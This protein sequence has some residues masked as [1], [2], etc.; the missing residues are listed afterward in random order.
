[1]RVFCLLLLGAA[2]LRAQDVTQAAAARAAGVERELRGAVRITGR[3]DSVFTLDERMRYYHVPGVSVAIIEDNRLVY[4]KG[5][6]V[7]EFGDTTQVDTTTLFLAGSISKPVFATGVLKLVQ[8]GKL[9]L[10]EDVNARLKSWRLPASHFTEKEKVT[11]R[12]ILTHTAGLTVWGFPGYA[13]TATVPTV[14]QVLD[15]EKPANTD[16]VRNDTTPGARWLYSGGGFTIAQLL[17]SDVTGESFPALMRRLVLAPAGMNRST[18]ENPLP[19]ARHGEAATGHEVIDTPIPGRFHTYPEMSAAGLW[20][21]AADLARWAID[22]SRAFNG[23]TGRILS[24]EMARQMISSQVTT[25]P[26]GGNRVWGLSVA[27]NGTG[28]SIS[29]SHGGRDEGFVASAMMWPKLGRGYVIL[30]NGVNGAVLAEF[31]RAFAHVYGVAAPARPER[32]IVMLDSAVRSAYAGTYFNVVAGD[33]I[34]YEIGVVGSALML[35]SSQLKRR[36]QLWPEGQ[37]TFFDAHTNET[38]TFERDGSGPARAFRI[39]TS[40]NAP[41]ILRRP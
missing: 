14:R 37:N 7:T 11:L 13:A 24:P 40:A 34:S 26:Q 18:Y 20:T 22:L 23:D 1:M 38:F 9:P 30:T 19:A 31:R 33:A 8:Q 17:A 29:F 32:R 10:D 3:P 28:D 39:G 27:L 41:R 25:G 15:G 5:F 36:I 6:G 16:A 35:H 12:R 21:T 4:A 2:A